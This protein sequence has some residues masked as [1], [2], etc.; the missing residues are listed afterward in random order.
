MA[1]PFREIPM[2]RTWGVV[3]VVLLAGCLSAG[4]SSNSIEL[5]FDFNVVGENWT[6]GVSD[7]PAAQ[8]GTV[9]LTAE[10]RALPAGLPS[11]NALYLAGTNTTGSMFIFME[12]RFTGLVP[13]LTY[14]A[15]LAVEFA[16]NIHQ[17]CTTGIG[18][19]TFIK[20]GAS[21][22]EPES[23]EIQG[24][25]RMIIDK[26]TGTSAG[27]YTQLGDIRNG[28]IGCPATGTWAIKTTAFRKQSLP[29]TTDNFGGFWLWV[30]L[31]STAVGRP[32]VYF[33]GVI[34]RLSH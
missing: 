26:G 33:G 17:G 14:D 25:L 13:N 20:A 8:V 19:T 21:S 1:A 16:S 27:D 31:E 10:L 4:D 29:V 11:R 32:E 34:L 5:P 2:K 9:N 7:V 30:A 23:E 15:E 3:A 24:V 18:T 12:K 22:V 28:E 6:A